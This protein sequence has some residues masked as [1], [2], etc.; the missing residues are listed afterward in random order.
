VTGGRW[1]ILIGRGVAGDIAVQ[2]GH[3]IGAEWRSG[4]TLW[5]LQLSILKGRG[6]QGVEIY[7]SNPFECLTRHT[8]EE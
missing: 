4:L 2:E 8:L 1:R 3:G 6:G 5:R 7:S